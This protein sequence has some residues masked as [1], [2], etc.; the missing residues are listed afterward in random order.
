MIMD[1]FPILGKGLTSILVLFLLTKLMGRKQAG[2]LNMFDYVVGITIG[3]I[4]AEMTLNNEVNFFEGIFAVAI[5]AFVAYGISLLTSKSIIARRLIN[6]VP[7]IVVQDGKI[8]V[9]NLKKAKLDTGDLL[10]EARNNGYFNL[11]EVEYA[12]LESNGKISFLLKSKYQPVTPSDMKLKVPYKGLCANLVMDGNIMTNNLK[13]IGK[14]G[15]WLKTRLHRLGY[16]DISKLFLVICDAS[17]V[18]TIYEKEVS[19]KEQKVLD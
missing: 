5:Y 3:S 7:T 8:L 11:S 14:T 1:F 2:Q 13:M 12:I 16:D 6:G 19:T 4:A 9:Q 17:E 18:L 15:Q 10:Q